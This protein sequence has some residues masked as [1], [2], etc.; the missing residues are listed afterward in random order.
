MLSLD[1]SPLLKRVN[2]ATDKQLKIHW[3]E[4]TAIEITNSFIYPP[5][6]D[7]TAAVTV[8]ILAAMA[9]A[10]DTPVITVGY[11]EGVG[12]STAGGNTAA[13]TGTTAAV[14]SVTIAAGDVGVA[15][16][17]ATITLVPGAHTTDAV[18]V[19]GVW[20]EYTRA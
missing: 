12:D 3:T 17:A 14:Y 2:G 5:D 16:K 20:C 11:W 10:I 15:P 6:L 1:T 7:D 9:G 19:Y 18:I 8:K 13:V 4:G